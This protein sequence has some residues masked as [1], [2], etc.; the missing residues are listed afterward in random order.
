MYLMIGMDLH[1]G[2]AQLGKMRGITNNSVSAILSKC[3]RH[4]QI[5]VIKN[6]IVNN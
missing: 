1:L 2:A 4:F 5:Y 6:L 3:C